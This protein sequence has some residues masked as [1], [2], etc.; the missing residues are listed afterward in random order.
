MFEPCR[1]GVDRE[2]SGFTACDFIP[3]QRRRDPG[4]GGGTDRVGGGD[5]AILGI[6]VVVEEDTVALFFPPAAG[7]DV[8]RTPFDFTSE[9][10][11]GPTDL[12]ECPA[13]LDP[14]IDVETSRAGGLGPA[15]QAE[16]IEDL[17]RRQ[18]HL[19]NL[20]PRHARNRIEIDAQLVRVVEV[21]GAHGMRIEI[22]AAEV[23]DPRQLGGVRHDDF[24]G[25]SA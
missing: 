19:A 23:D 5:R 22:N 11:R 3:R 17:T 12:R 21:G 9:S 14:A 7:G 18:C 24:F 8:G 2:G 25:G 1:D 13:W 16:V 20:R 4:I 10:N 6:L 15:G